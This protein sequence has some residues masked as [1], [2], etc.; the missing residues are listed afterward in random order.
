MLIGG[1]VVIILNNLLLHFTEE[2][3]ECTGQQT[4]NISVFVLCYSKINQLRSEKELIN[5]ETDQSVIHKS[6]RGRLRERSLTRDL[7]TE[8]K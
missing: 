5:K 4:I 1:I 6:G 7:F 2:V 8:F 3:R